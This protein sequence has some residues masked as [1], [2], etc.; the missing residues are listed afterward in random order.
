MEVG[1]GSRSHSEKNVLENH[2]KI[3]VHVVLLLFWGSI[4]RIFCL[5]IIMY[6]I[7]SC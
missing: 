2:P 4:L 7:I 6:V 3:H 1:G 5:Y